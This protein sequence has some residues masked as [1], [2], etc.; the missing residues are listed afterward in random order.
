MRKLIEISLLT[1][2][3]SLLLALPAASQSGSAE[4]ED[5]QKER[6]WTKF[7]HTEGILEDGYEER[8][9]R[10][11]LLANSNAEH[12]TPAMTIQVDE[13]LDLD[14]QNLRET[15]PTASSIAGE[16]RFDDKLPDVSP[17]A[18]QIFRQRSASL[19][20]ILYTVDRSRLSE[21]DLLNWELLAYELRDRLI[22]WGF[23]PEL[24]PMSALGGLQVWL[25]QLGD[26]LSFTEEQHYRDYVVR[27]EK[28]PKLIEDTMRNMRLGL[29]RGY[30][31]PGVTLRGVPAQIEAISSDE[32]LEDPTSHPM[33]APLKNRGKDD[34]LANRAR[35]AIQHGVIP[36]FRQ[37][38]EY[39]KTEYL[40]NCRE[41]IGARDG[42]NGLPFYE[43]R[44]R[45]FTT[46]NMT[47]KEV[48]DMGRSEV[49][50]IKAEMLEVIQQTDFPEKNRFEGDLL[51]QAFINY[52]RS[53]SRF[54]FDDPEDLLA[55]YRD[56]GKRMDAE[57]PA[58]FG[59][60]PRLSW[61]VR[62]MPSFFAESAPTAYYYPGS[63][64]NGVSGTFIANVSK[65]D[66]RPKYE[67]IPL[68]LHEA[69]PGHHFQIAIA[70]ELEYEGLH[71]WRTLLGYTAYVEGWALYAERLGLEVGGEPGSKGMYS[72]PYDDFGRLSYEMWR[73]LRLVVDTGIHA[74]G[75]TRD[76]AIDYMLANSSLSEANVIN[77]VDR[78]IAWPGQA[79]GYKIGE[80]RIRELRAR[81]EEKLGDDFNIRD[82][83]DM[84]LGAGALPLSVLEKRVDRWIET[85]GSD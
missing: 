12:A 3:A 10:L 5:R 60:L 44:V 66:Q 82:F 71:E 54:Y 29:S 70:Q 18:A 78:Y 65:L 21:E 19:Q 37:L 15:F 23:R 6:D 53:D 22:T 39:M 14:L 42:V 1:L 55:A 47:A 51:F 38:G 61:G 77:E 41:T 46:T 79:L 33:Y 35:L 58:L 11:T 8:I 25:P 16:R 2:V 4:D 20:T 26:R 68:T 24:E 32:Q 81:A 67:M 27:L 50:R 63:L 49:A 62:A 40:P 84:L 75:W 30:S 34:Q 56:I 57:L 28:T 83:H 74:F 64:E 85:T 9:D 72:D 76:Q 43:S 17:E 48:H 73:A 7:E 13:L 59:R 69:V 45:H 52:L 36:A 31:P 80:I